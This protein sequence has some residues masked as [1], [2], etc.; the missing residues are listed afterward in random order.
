MYLYGK[1]QVGTTTGATAGITLPAGFTVDSS[2]LEAKSYLGEF[3]EQRSTSTALYP[4]TRGVIFFNNDSGAI[5]FTKTSN[6]NVYVAD[7]ADVV[8]GS[9]RFIDLQARIPIAQ[10]AGSGTVNLAQ[11]DVEYASVGGTWDAASTTTVYGPSGFA[12]GGT[13]AGPREKTIT[14]Q[15]P[16][17]PTDRIQVWGSKDRINWFPINGC[18][19][20]STNLGVVPSMEAAG[21]APRAGV[22][23]RPGATAYETIVTFARY[24][25]IANDDAPAE[26]WPSSDAFWVVTKSRAGQAV[27]FGT[28]S[29]NSSGLM[30]ANHSN[31]DD[32][33]ATR[34]G[35]KSYTHGV[36]YAGGNQISISSTASSWT[37]GSTYIIPKQMQDGSWRLEFSIVGTLAA[38]QTSVGIVISGISFAVDNQAITLSTNTGTVN[39]CITNVGTG[40]ITVSVNSSSTGIRMSGIVSLSAK[41]TWAY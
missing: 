33:A 20:G 3:T 39:R 21:G 16:V 22:N 37:Y 13:L 4:N 23:W 5:A 28:V 36:S 24:I 38:G 12:I 40:E 1:F 34:L 30:P 41:P 11:N 9:N 35:L 26:N 6:S 14:W 15:T 8:S 7:N 31:L 18:F 29:Q 19:L 10:W 25:N 32:A 2:A 27:G 17:Q